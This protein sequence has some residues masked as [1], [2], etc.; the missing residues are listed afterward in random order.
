[1]GTLFAGVAGV[2]ISRDTRLLVLHKMPPADPSWATQCHLFGQTKT[3][4]SIEPIMRAARLTASPRF[5]ISPG[6]DAFSVSLRIHAPCIRVPPHAGCGPKPRPC[7]DRLLH[8]EDR[9]CG[10]PETGGK[11]GEK[12]SVCIYNSWREEGTMR[13]FGLPRV[14]RRGEGGGETMFPWSPPWVERGCIAML[15]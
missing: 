10:H 13:L 2:D 3:T 6:A 14:W 5:V 1:M 8:G 12:N 4:L 11:R 7:P 15:P 9:R